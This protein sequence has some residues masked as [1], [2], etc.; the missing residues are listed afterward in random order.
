[1]NK[2]GDGKVN[3]EAFKGERNPSEAAKK[4]QGAYVTQ[5]GLE[6]IEVNREGPGGNKSFESELGKTK[7]WCRAKR[8]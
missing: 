2:C 7:T 5:G 8:V 1:M 6:K 4:S 3:R